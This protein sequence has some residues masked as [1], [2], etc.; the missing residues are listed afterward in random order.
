MWT[1]WRWH[2]INNRELLA[3]ALPKEWVPD[4]ARQLQREGR[5]RFIG[6]STHATTDIILEAVETGEF[7]YLTSTGT[8]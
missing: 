1:C 2:G 6:F 4:A 5:T 7:D 8:S 3:Y